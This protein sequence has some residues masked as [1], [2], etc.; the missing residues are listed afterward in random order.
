MEGERRKCIFVGGEASSWRKGRGS[1]GSVWS[2]STEQ[3]RHTCRAF[4]H[5]PNSMLV[6]STETLETTQLA[7]KVG[8][9][10]KSGNALPSFLNDA[11]SRCFSTLRQLPYTGFIQIIFMD[12][13]T[14]VFYLPFLSHT[15][16]LHLKI[17]VTFPC[18][19][20]LSCS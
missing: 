2:G 12:D 11:Q 10:V 14:F 15:N 7:Q 6:L 1:T 5:L 4:S 20:E 8:P 17:L 18:H 3:T 16:Q 13:F 9:D 19:S